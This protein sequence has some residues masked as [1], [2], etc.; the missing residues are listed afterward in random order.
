[1]AGLWHC[2]T[3]SNGDKHGATLLV[4]QAAAD[5][6]DPEAQYALGVLYA[7]LLED[8]HWSNFS[9]GL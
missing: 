3:P 8:R 2:F 7:N 9:G 5:E 6:G 4:S 1:M